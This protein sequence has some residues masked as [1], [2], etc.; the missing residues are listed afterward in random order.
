MPVPTETFW[1]MKRLNVIFL[2]CA[3]ALMLSTLW[4]I[5]A[6]FDKEWRG[7]QE[8]GWAWEA[9]MV[10]ARQRDTAYLTDEIA[11]LNTQIANL[12]KQLPTERI[13]QLQLEIN[14]AG[15]EVETFKLKAAV[16]KGEIVP[17]TQKIE[18][19]IIA[20]GEGAEEVAAL[21]EELAEIVA[22]YEG[23][24]EQISAWK[25]T[26]RENEAEIRE[27][28][29]SVK[30]VLVE[31]G[32][33]EL[34]RSTLDEQL[35]FVAP[36]G[37]R[38]IGDIIRDE[39]LSGIAWTNPKQKVQQVVVPDVRTELNFLTVETIDRCQTCHVNID[40]PAFSTDNLNTFVAGEL[41]REMG[42]SDITGDATA[43]V[44][45]EYWQRT[46][47][48]LAADNSGM[49]KAVQTARDTALKNLNDVREAAE[50]D[51]L[52]AE[53]LDN[54][55]ANLPERAGNDWHNV[56]RWYVEDLK[57]LI[58]RELDDDA[59]KQVNDLHRVALVEEY[60][61]ARRQLGRSAL[62]TSP[63][64]MAHPR[65]DL[66][67]EE[68]SEH[69]KKTM[70]CTVCHEGS[71]QETLF[72]H[73]AHTPR[74]IWVDDD[75]GAPVPVFLVKQRGTDHTI[76]TFI[77]EHNAAPPESGDKP[78]IAAAS[79]SMPAVVAAATAA[80]KHGDDKAHVADD[81]AHAAYTHADV[82]LN[83]EHGGA[84][85]APNHEGHAEAAAYVNPA[86]P[87]V[88]R[89]AIRQPARWSREYG[90]HV[91][92][93]MHWEK[94]MHSL[95]YVQSACAKCHTD[96][97]E[98]E[99]SAPK[100]FEG[101]RLFA[102]EGCVNCHAVEG[103]KDDLDIKQ[104][105]PS[106]VHVKDKLTEQMTSTWIWAPK[107][108]RPTTRMP[109][110]FMLENNS[111]P[112]DILR[113]RVEVAAIARYLRTAEPGDIQKLQ[114]DI[115]TLLDKLD[116]AVDVDRKAKLEQELSDLEAQLARARRTKPQYEPE[117]PPDLQ[118]IA[119][120]QA[121][122]EQINADTA[123]ARE[124]IPQAE[125]LEKKIADLSNRLTDA[126]EDE[127][128]DLQ[129]QFDAAKAE[130][131]KLTEQL[132]ELLPGEGEPDA[133]AQIAALEEQIEQ[134]KQQPI[135]GDELAGK[136]IYNT[137][138]CVAC[139]TN[140]N[141]EGEE[142]VVGDMTSRLGLDE[143][144]AKQR[145]QN[146]SY[147]QR[148]WYVLEHLEDQ[149][150]LVGP[151]LSAVG[152]K[153]LAGRGV[154]ERDEPTAEAMN[155]ARV[156]LYDWLRNPR[157]Y[158]DYTIMPSFRLTPDETNHLVRYLLEQRR[159]GATFD[160]AYLPGEF[161][162]D[163]SAEKTMLRELVAI[164]MSGQITVDMAREEIDTRIVRGTENKPYWTV[165]RQLEFL[166]QKMI[167][168]YGCNGC[169][170]I[171]G[172]ETAASACTNLDEWGL[173]DPHKLDF[174]YFHEA[175]AKIREKPLKVYKTDHEGLEAGAAKITPRS[176]G[177][178]A[179]RELA[180]EHIGDAR[181]PW[182]YH[183]LHNTRVYD[184][185]KYPH[186]YDGRPVVTDD[187]R[188]AVDLPYL[189]NYFAESKPYDRLKMPKF[190][191]RDAQ[192]H[193]LV[194]Y[195]TSIRKPLVHENLQQVATPAGQRATKGRQI[196]ALYN[197]KACHSIEGG[198]PYIQQHIDGAF[199]TN[200]KPDYQKVPPRLVGQGAKTQ[201]DWLVHFLRN[202]E[203]IRPTVKVR[204]PS[205]PLS[206][207]EATAFADYF[208][209]WAQVEAAQLKAWDEQ[210]QK[211]RDGSDRAINALNT[212]KAR[213]EGPN[214]PEDKQWVQ[215]RLDQIPTL[216]ARAEQ[217]W[218]Y[219][220]D[221]QTARPL[222]TDDPAAAR[223]LREIET[224]AVRMDL[225]DKPTNL[226]G[227]YTDDESLATNWKYVHR[228]VR[229]LADLN[230]VH[231]PF[232]SAPLPQYD[233]GKFERGKKLFEAMNCAQCHVQGDEVMLQAI[234]SLENPDGLKKPG[235]TGGDDTGGYGEDAEG[236][237]GED[238]DG[239]YGED[240]E[241][242]Y[243]EDA[244]GGY[245]EGE[246]D[247]ADGEAKPM[248]EAM[249]APLLTR[250]YKHTAPNLHRVG[251]KIQWD[252]FGK[253]IQEPGVIMPGTA[254]F[255]QFGGPVTGDPKYGK[256][257]QSFFAKVPQPMR[258]EMQAK[259]GWTGDQQMDFLRHY[260]YWSTLRYY[261][262]KA[263]K[264]L[265][266]EPEAIE[267]ALLERPKIDPA[268]IERQPGVEDGEG[269]TDDEQ[270]AGPT[271]VKKESDIALHDSE[272]AYEGDA[273]FGNKTRV[274]GVIKLDAPRPK[275]TPL[276]LSADSYCVGAHPDAPVFVENLVVTK[277]REVSNILVR[278]TNPP[279]GDFKPARS[280]VLLDQVGCV[281]IPH[282]QV[283]TTGQTLAVRNSDNTLHNVNMQSKNNGSANVGQPVMGM[284]EN[285]ELSK[286]ELGVAFKCDVHPWMG[287]FVH[288]LEHPFFAV[289]D[290]EGR[291]E[292]RGLPP[293]T[294]TVE[295]LHASGLL[296]SKSFE[297]EVKADTSVRQDV[298]LGRD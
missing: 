5:R 10:R 224:W 291:F 58:R 213:L 169:H 160:E 197:C 154:N 53:Q 117:L 155:E 140:L 216:I 72:E 52:E 271:V 200:G 294:Y 168:H 22:D 101:R 89:K 141:E 128:E 145:Y 232:T 234:W 158:S 27:L 222:A 244:E 199:Q 277:N 37:L 147:N 105:G 76:N 198:D 92:H 171:N 6:D 228:C 242:G 96:V 33:L 13:E 251:H 104:V 164:L 185:G 254:M 56:L 129:K 93:Y 138:G 276:D 127:K 54:A 79:V 297:I 107:A 87:G 24:N 75:T 14:A 279:S 108:F 85:F 195:V 170:K 205:F 246:G 57:S 219:K 280:K 11:R 81:R 43:L 7:Y 152:S 118:A 1:N 265:G 208:S 66:Y 183:K 180:W 275:R 162:V 289:S 116:V 83:A 287:A 46:A 41:A 143:A 63:V 3:V 210:L 214:A 229:F 249:P 20:H 259:F 194:T 94:P 247:E 245:G 131:S 295:T 226:D 110:Y 156:W 106:L 188:L 55:L 77:R 12:E 161:A 133:A 211:L 282:V 26:I 274:V 30:E 292:I 100:L 252:W 177:E 236:G 285:F 239:G 272:V 233:A 28:R 257:P 187:G 44:G 139:H 45:Y 18:K 298:T 82:N 39:P 255:S 135:P 15:E 80:P 136:Q 103:L 109:H 50:L 114:R 113:T 286:P 49:G 9:A 149:V 283:K 263:E 126:G 182:L 260:V 264:V 123:K 64:L 235:D 95:Q 241:G 29:E 290:V 21:R 23:L 238:A 144:T 32:N 184:R 230:D 250:M 69:P 132:K 122:I 268:D 270:P 98:L 165:D 181:R 221:G 142:L 237:Y 174:G 62:S 193:A 179:E 253:W 172:F 99:E 71:G 204:M 243:G 201:H 231:Y 284:V 16:K 4:F 269:G 146:M 42:W 67:L 112:V 119:D 261:T 225:L 91:I 78:Q 65:L 35:A 189:S 25:K 121:Q 36:E 191:L 175:Y 256:T 167:S 186:T 159:P 97:Y 240:A 90:W 88:Y 102:T 47:S 60:N 115:N 176:R 209:G 281:Y 202:V 248:I 258:D 163:D 227:R 48:M 74:D 207:D 120:L 266:I 150:Q 153:L 293:G 61:Q 124:L 192:V 38:K 125:E 178:I 190:Y 278:V 203:P 173:K 134:T 267:L 262:P 8:A 130:Q 215:S 220:Y 273:V 137:V 223:T 218:A 151:E 17:T 2:I 51:A 217:W 212:E 84:P 111:S 70:G 148:H 31:Q 288:V 86:Q 40:D 157:H 206:V 166:G 196:A 34:R 296:E 59:W 73:T 68:G 19:A